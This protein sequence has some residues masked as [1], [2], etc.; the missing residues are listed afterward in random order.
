MDKEQLPAIYGQEADFCAGF[1]TLQKG[2]DIALLATGVLVHRAIEAAR[3]LADEGISVRVLDVFRLKPV[4][5]KA[6]HT[7][8]E[9]IN[10]VLTVE[11]NSPIG[12]LS[13][14]I[15][16]LIARHDRQIT[17]DSVALND[18][19]MMSA[20]SRKWAEAKYGLTLDS[21]ITK[22]RQMAKET[23]KV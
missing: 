19:A 14:I 5:A 6:L 23:D 8:I 13:S 3:Q 2:S 12:G 7:A 17:F 9:D 4:D 16:E 20:A 15:A 10:A 18:E 22:L 1:N 11:E 21:I